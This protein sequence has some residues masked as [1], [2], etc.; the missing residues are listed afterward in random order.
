MLSLVIFFPLAAGLVLLV[1]P[2][3]RPR[4]VRWVALLAAVTELALTLVLLA[5]FNAN[6]GLQ[7]ETDVDWIPSLGAGYSIGV[8]G[9]SLPL[10]ILTALLTAVAMVYVLPERQHTRGHAF[11]FLLMTTGLIGV[12]AS[13]DLLLFYAFF[14]VGLVPMYFIIGIWGHENRRYAAIKFFL[15]TRAGS[16]AMLL[17]F[18]GLYLS[19]SPRTFSL[20]ELAAQSPL[21]G[22]GAAL[23]LLGL[24]LGFGVKLPIFPLHNWLPDAHVEAPTEGSV[25]LA[26]A[27]LKMGAY[28]FIVV[29][30][31][32]L[33]QA[34]R[35]YAPWLLAIALITLVYGALAA[36]AQS[37]LKRL[38]AY[39][40]VNHMGYVIL[41]LAVWGL[42]DD[43]DVRRLALNGAAVQAVSHG[44]L[45]GGLFLLV[46]MLQARGHTREMSRFSGLLQ[47]APRY[48]FLLAA[49]AFGSLGLPGFSGFVAEFQVLG[50]TVSEQLWAAAVVVLGLV[51]MT[52]LFILVLVRI[53]MGELSLPEPNFPDLDA[54]EAIASVPLVVLSLAIGVLP[55]LL[56]RYIDPVSQQ[57][58][59]LP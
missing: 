48:S 34:T 44:L 43:G 45:T 47:A 1:L 51:I 38:V 25:L 50:A 9:I 10:I 33:P 28:G 37:D 19:S 35:E 54:R 56:L 41:G 53:V 49:L 23:A 42:A 13:R 29:V 59:T 4:L 15:Y 12:F 26:G 8:T 5:G 27:Q 21:S 2:A 31:T 6:G 46:G 57:L 7:W 3:S 52:A 11:L 24:V 22:T 55:F 16:L 58:S 18:L 39:T 40:S 17:S 32:L 30:P 36:L 20:D 14:E